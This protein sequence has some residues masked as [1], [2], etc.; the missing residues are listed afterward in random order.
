MRAFLRGAVRGTAIFFAL[1]FVVIM[2]S[3]RAHA[4]RINMTVTDKTGDTHFIGVEIHPPLFDYGPRLPATAPRTSPPIRMQINQ[5]KSAD[6][7]ADYILKTE[8]REAMERY[9]R[10]DAATRSGEGGE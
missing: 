2:L 1:L 10:I 7:F 4:E 9:L 8:G 3:T 5:I 6:S